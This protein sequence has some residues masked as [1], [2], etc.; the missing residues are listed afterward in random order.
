[1]SSEVTCNIIVSKIMQDKCASV[2]DFFLQPIFNL[3]TFQCVG[4]EVLM[5]GIHRQQVIAPAVLLPQVGISDSI[6]NIGNHIIREAFLF[7]RDEIL[8]IKPDFFLCINVATHQLNAPESAE[9]IL[10]MQKLYSIP[11]TAIIF[12]ITASEEPLTETGEQTVAML[13]TVGFGIA[14][15]DVATVEHVESKLTQ[16]PSDYIKLDRR[17]LKLQHL[18]TTED[19]IYQAQRYGAVVIAEG[20]ETMAQTSM[21]L[22]HN[23]EL[24][25]GYLFSR[26][27]K[28]IAFKQQFIKP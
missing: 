10:N 15:D 21:L 26:P 5:R 17:C 7:L 14:W 12:E 1:M 23:V 24:A 13:Q 6:I 16:I 27:L 20:V 25:Q 4:A 22:K 11:A 2:I 9:H 28:K 8:P 3:S 19:V 18:Q